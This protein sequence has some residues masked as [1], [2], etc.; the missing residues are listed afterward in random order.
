MKTSGSD[1]VSTTVT[2]SGKFAGDEIVQLYIHQKIAFVTRPVRELKGFQRIHLAPGE[3]KTAR[4]AITPERLAIYDLDLHH[5][6]E[7]GEFE[8]IIA[9]S[10][11]AGQTAL[12]RANQ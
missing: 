8:I 11:D 3:S 12:A 4:F 2:K 5:V 10:A 6:I 7:P 9:P 1:E